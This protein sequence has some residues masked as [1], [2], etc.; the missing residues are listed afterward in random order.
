MFDQL[1]RNIRFKIKFSNH[2]KYPQRFSKGVQF[3][4]DFICKQMDY[5]S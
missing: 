2:M 1:F 4:N 3:M 5:F